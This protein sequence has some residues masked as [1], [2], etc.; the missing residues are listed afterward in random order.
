MF[1]LVFR[2][3][4]V[5]YKIIYTCKCSSELLLI[6]EYCRISPQQHQGT[7][8]SP[9][10][11]KPSSSL[12]LSGDEDQPDGKETIQPDATTTQ[13]GND[14]KNEEMSS[15]SASVP[16]RLFAFLVCFIHDIKLSFLEIVCVFNLYI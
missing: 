15:A 1:C 14:H 13:H 16:V 10:R 9:Q 8:R 3:L 7:S 4:H 2:L 5:L 12:S 11:V 6:L